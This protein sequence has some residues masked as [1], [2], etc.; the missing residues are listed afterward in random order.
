[1]ATEFTPDGM[2]T[3][4]ATL[5]PLL[6]DGAARFSQW[7][8]DNGPDGDDIVAFIETATSLPFSDGWNA[9]WT[10]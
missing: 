2:A 1:M 8:A 4:L 7:V 9:Y 10:S 3:K 5:Y 6:P